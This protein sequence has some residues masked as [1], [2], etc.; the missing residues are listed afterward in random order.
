MKRSTKVCWISFVF[1]TLVIAAITALAVYFVLF[2][3]PAD[4][5]L[6]AANPDLIPEDDLR[7][8]AVAGGKH[9]AAEK[10]GLFDHRSHAVPGG[11]YY[12][13]DY[14]GQASGIKVQLD[15]SRSH[16]HYFDEG[17]PVVIGNITS[18]FWF[19]K[20]S[21]S[22]LGNGVKPTISFTRGKH[23]VGLT[24]R[25]NTR[26]T[27]TDYTNVF[28]LSPIFEG[29]YCYY[30]SATTIPIPIDDNIADGPRPVAA[31]VKKV[32]AF[33]SKAD[34][35]PKFQSIAFTQ[36]CAFVAN[37]AANTQF[38]I[39]H[40]GNVR[41]NIAGENIPLVATTPGVSSG[42]YLGATST[43]EETEIAEIAGELIF[44]CTDP[45][46][47]TVALTKG[48]D[49]WQHD[50][51]KVVPVVSRVEP[52]TSTKEGG[53]K[54]KVY[55]SGLAHHVKVQ[56]G[57]ASISPKNVAE[58]GT[59]MDVVVPAVASEQRVSITANNP[60][61]A[62][63]VLNFEYSKDGKTPIKFKQTQ[64]T[65]GDVNHISGIKYGPDHRFYATSLSG[66]VY[67]FKLGRNLKL[68]DKICRSPSM[69]TN[70]IALGL[71]FNYAITDKVRL[72]VSTSILEWKVR[73][74]LTGP[75][76]WA[77]GEISI[78]ET[79]VDGNCLGK[80]GDPII[81]G[82]PV[83]N[84]DHG[85][86]GMVFDDDGNLHIQVGGFTNAGHN[87]ADSKLGGIDENP[88]SGASLIAYVN[89][90]TF[91]G[92]VTYSNNDPGTAK[93]IGGKDVQVYSAGWRNSFGINIH[94]NGHIYATDNGASKGFGDMSTSCTE[95]KSLPGTQ[96]LKD[97]LA[98]VVRG[99][100]MGHPNRNRGRSDK[101]QCKFVPVEANSGA[102]YLKPIATFESSTNGVVE[103]T[104]DTFGGQLKGNLILSK[105]AT[106]QSPGKLF[107]VQL[108]DNGQL[109]ENVD[110]DGLWEASGVS[111][112][113]TPW[114]DLLT[115]RVY[116]KQIVAVRPDTIRSGGQ[117]FIS[118][119][120]NRG[121]HLGGN[122]VRVA[123][124]NI[125]NNPV[126]MFD[127]VA[128]TDV[129]MPTSEE[130]FCTTPKGIRGKGVRVSIVSTS[131]TTTSAGGV[132]FKYMNV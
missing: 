2:R 32:L 85:V 19:D 73:N 16:T 50:V 104:A 70:R 126:A 20:N 22:V 41:L 118:V 51:S 81:T 58:D 25:D 69:G 39:N 62:S 80:V 129:S 10:S 59:W 17:P 9:K 92:K 72:Y 87:V 56:F 96:N 132:D 55:G 100:Y 38:T 83:S 13:I 71:A 91:D 131:G 48:V 111:V 3:K 115:P 46:T 125:G 4:S 57:A 106:D 112:E 121:S 27:H 79:D 1:S 34:F 105:F 82:L 60:N 110:H 21:G 122:I 78:L 128:C 66:H 107:R 88:L 74:R 75:F 102:G 18:M 61:G 54:V 120:P 40:N 24:V 52:T 116:Q 12:G 93:K 103:Y 109:K 7:P 45:A 11:D 95:H 84:H 29:V 97:K 68:A 77:N 47:C 117:T 64:L 26:D 99:K 53:G 8:P 65:L 114:G 37:I 23:T 101:K 14:A 44:S 63:G 30:Y 124:N 108:D 36:R 6:A 130:F 76:A 42:T 5:S 28:V 89:K 86:N 119:M 33:N 49:K 90:P 123:G 15:G 35:P 127:G 94:T 98:K 67:A 31:G 113:I 43:A